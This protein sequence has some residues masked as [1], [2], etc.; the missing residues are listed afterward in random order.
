MCFYFYVEL[1]KMNYQA[2]LP[3]PAATPG[4]STGYDRV[5][6]QQVHT[7]KMIIINYDTRCGRL[8]C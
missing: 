6:K 5:F 1:Q 7:S 2:R 8:Q 3:L 4:E